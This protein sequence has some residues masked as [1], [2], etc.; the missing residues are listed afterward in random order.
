KRYAVSNTCRNAYNHFVNKP[1]NHA[2]KRAFHACGHYEYVC[3]CK[4]FLIRKKAVYAGY[5][6]VVNPFHLVAEYFGRKGSFLGDR[7]IRCA[8]G[9]YSYYFIYFLHW[10]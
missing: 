9:Y 2:R 1:S 6:Y 7:D 5:A 8:C 3:F 4:N 10:L